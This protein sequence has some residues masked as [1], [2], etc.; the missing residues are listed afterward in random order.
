MDDI[1]FTPLNYA[2]AN[3]HRKVA[4]FLRDNGGILNQ[5]NDMGTLFCTYAY[6]GDLDT[7]RLYY[8]CGANLMMCDYDKRSLAH[9]AAAEGKLDIIKFVVQETHFNIMIED[10]WGNTPYVD[11][12]PEIKAYIESR[13]RIGK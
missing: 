1:K 3:K 10:R 4:L 6:E 12:T 11:A 9:I 2:C 8:D 7:I 13:F 5:S